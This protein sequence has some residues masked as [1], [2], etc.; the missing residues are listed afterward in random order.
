M[1]QEPGGSGVNA[2][3]VYSDEGKTIS[4]NVNSRAE[5]AIG[6][7]RLS[8][9]DFSGLMMAHGGGD[10]DLIGFVFSFQDN[11]NFYVV[12]SSQNGSN[13]GPWKIVRVASTDLKKLASGMECLLYETN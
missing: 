2:V 12:Y 10:D 5:V 1:S 13:Q 3:W 6:R 7:A 4:Q 11:H 8:S 9:V